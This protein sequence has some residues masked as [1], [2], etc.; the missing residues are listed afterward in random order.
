MARAATSSSA[1]TLEKVGLLEGLTKRDRQRLARSM[2]T[3][4]FAAGREVVVQDRQGVG[5]FIITDGKAAVSIGGKTIDM[6]GPGDYF[7][8]MALID[9]DR[10]TATVTADSDLECL[11]MT[12]WE[13][14]P[15][16]AEHP[17][18][19]WALLQTLARRVRESADR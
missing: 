4:K 9:G 6:I 5:F 2:K 13:F 14:K 12:S 16:V 8:E 18:V 11:S 10:R 15:F 1:D 3:R 7:G 19:A 17:S